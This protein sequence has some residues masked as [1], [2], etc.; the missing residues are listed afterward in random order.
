MSDAIMRLL[1]CLRK[2]IFFFSNPA[3]ELSVLAQVHVNAFYRQLP[4]EAQH[5]S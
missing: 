2:G 3:L 1:L 4:S 5:Q